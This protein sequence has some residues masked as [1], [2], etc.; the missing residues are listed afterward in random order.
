VSAVKAYI[1]GERIICIIR[2]KTIS[3]ELVFQLLV[4]AN[5]APSSLM[6]FTLLMEAII[7]L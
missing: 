3:Y 1:S 6:L 2:E 7:F 4:T 5:V